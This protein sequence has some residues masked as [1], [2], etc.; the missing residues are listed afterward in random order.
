MSPN[1]DQVRSL[2]SHCT[3]SWGLLVAGS[4]VLAR[5]DEPVG[6]RA[7]HD[8]LNEDIRQ[9]DLTERVL[10]PSSASMEARV[11]SNGG[12]PSMRT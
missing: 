6:L 1:A 8:P 12:L 10:R 2:A 7:V 4:Q 11:S 3:R 9:L 5:P